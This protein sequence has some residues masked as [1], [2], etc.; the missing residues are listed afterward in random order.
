MARSTHDSTTGL[1]GSVLTLTSEARPIFTASVT[2]T[3]MSSVA[4]QALMNGPWTSGAPSCALERGA[5]CRRAVAPASPFE[6]PASTTC[7]GDAAKDDAK[8]VTEELSISH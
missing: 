4:P 5:V 2:T 6:A 8:D 7:D 3:F 1:G